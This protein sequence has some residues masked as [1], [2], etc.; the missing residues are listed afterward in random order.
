MSAGLRKLL[1][2]AVLVVGL[3]GVAA[4]VS[5]WVWSE[6]FRGEATQETP[7]GDSIAVTL[8]G[9]EYSSTRT[10]LTLEL[11]GDFSADPESGLHFWSIDPQE[12][13][14]SGFAEPVLGEIGPLLDQIS[15]VSGEPGTDI[16][17]LVLPPIQDPDMPVRLEITELCPVSSGSYN[18]ERVS[19]QW[20]IEALPG[21]D[22]IDPISAH[23][24][25]GTVQEAEGI[26]VRLLEVARSSSEVVIAY[27][28]E[29]GTHTKPI[30]PGLQSMVLEDGTML[31]MAG[32]R[33]RPDGAFIASFP[34]LPE[35]YAG[36]VQ[37][38][39]GNYLRQDSLASESI[40]VQLS[41]HVSGETPDP[42][43]DQRVDIPVG[44]DVAVGSYSVRLQSLQVGGGEL[45]IYLSSTEGA[46]PILFGGIDGG[47][48]LIDGEGNGTN[49][50]HRLD[51][52]PQQAGGLSAGVESVLVFK[53]EAGLDVD[54][55]ELLGQIVHVA[56]PA[57]SFEVA[58]D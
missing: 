42:Q 28:F 30:G 21:E 1:P 58:L 41:D 54:S 6:A 8:V 44:L 53:I 5:A 48:F 4:L 45:V 32:Q 37:F 3:A 26:T 35:A 25:L 13:S 14:L 12:V 43:S 40:E 31:G 39:G 10:V 18:C 15:E 50:W 46:E 29:S 19:G 56:G 55:F 17:H 47:A 52:F 23:Q 7:V 24:Q 33:Y 9:E 20:V 38:A 51:S 27:T 11:Q 34:P 2:R 22:G 16:V 49:I 57:F 36:N